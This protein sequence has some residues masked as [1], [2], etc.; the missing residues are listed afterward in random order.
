MVPYA[1][2]TNKLPGSN[3]AEARKNAIEL[4]AEIKKKTKRKP[5]IRSAYFNKQKIF[6]EYFWQHL[7]DKGPK[8]RYKRLRYF[9]VAIELIKNSKNHP[10]TK[11][12]PNNPNEILHRF[13]GLTKNKEIFYVQI[14]ENRRN[15]KKYFISCFPPD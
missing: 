9:G 4:F 5:Y 8:E 12:N 3:Y 11:Q 7:Y 6:F 15:S 14:K 1:T 10:T 2:K 13:A